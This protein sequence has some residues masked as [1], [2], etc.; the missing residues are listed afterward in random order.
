MTGIL[1]HTGRKP[2]DLLSRPSTANAD[3]PDPTADLNLTL[4][5]DSKVRQSVILCR[6]PPSDSKV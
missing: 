6:S 4:H 2:S 1:P 5:I 3:F